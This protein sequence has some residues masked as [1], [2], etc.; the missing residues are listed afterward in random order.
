MLQLGVLVSGTGTNLQAIL[1]AIEG[2]RLD[3]RVRLVVSNKPDAPALARAERA[4]VPTRVL[5]HQGFASREQYDQKLVEALGEAGVELVVLAGFMRMLTP[6]FLRA[7]PGRVVN[8]HPSLLPAFP[9]VRAQAQALAHGV[10]VSGCTVHFVDEGVDTGAVIAQ[11]AVP[12]LEGDT[13]ESLTARILEQEHLLLVQA[14]GL[15]AAGRVELVAAEPG[16]RART[17]LRDG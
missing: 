10:K 6:V 15:L 2:G 16:A 8:I 7:F 11:R 13:E 1:D 3:A 5:G 9:G 17:R 14:L 4:G 12:V